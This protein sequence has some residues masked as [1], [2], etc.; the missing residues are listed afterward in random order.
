[1]KR[2][3]QTAWG[4][5]LAG[6]LLAGAAAAPARL[7]DVY[8]KNGLK[9]R[10]DVTETERVFLLRNAAGELS[11]PRADVA[12]LIYAGPPDAVSATQ[13]AAAS[14]AVPTEP[15][16]R[17][18]RAE[19]PPAPPLSKA[20]IQR[21]RLHELVLED[22]PEIVRVQFAK[23]GGQDLAAEVLA[24][25][26][27]RPDFQPQWEAVLTR[28]R[29]HEQLQLILRETGM[30]YADRITITSDTEVFTEFRKRVLPL[31]NQSCA[32]SGCHWGTTARVF[33]LP[34]GSRTGETFAYTAFVLFDQ[35]QTPRGKLIDRDN[36][37]ASL[38]LQYMLP[39]EDND[40]AHPPVGRGPTF[41][42]AIRGSDDPNYDAV[43][44]WIHYLQPEHPDYG[45]DYVNPYTRAADEV[46]VVPAEPKREARPRPPGPDDE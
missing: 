34:V 24:E 12:R 8:L 9:L 35:M 45:L 17:P 16:T 3:K 18:A 21:L 7:A 32:R 39:Q 13:P 28:G 11:I 40:R 43:V 44:D 42:P 38:L 30:K 41:K 27:Q 37:E 33:R 19:L 25:L 26:R 10:G 31:I 6:L 5:G 22:A 23:K 46:P 20:D 2:I 36:A 29:P 14:G 15:A 1:M 4:V